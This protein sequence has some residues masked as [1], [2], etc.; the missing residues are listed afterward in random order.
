MKR[1]LAAALLLLAL[2]GCES[3]QDRSARLEAQAAGASKPGKGLVVEQRS[4]AVRVVRAAALQDENGAAVVV[5]LR[6]RSRQALAALPI[7]VAV[8]DKG[9]KPLYANDA[10][11]LDRSL[12]S[13][14]AI[15]PRSRLL[16]VNDQVTAAGEVSRARAAVGVGGKRVA[17]ALPRLVVQGAR[18][19]GDP[20]SGIA[21][22]GRIANR[23][24]LEQRRLVVYVVALKGREIVA[25]GR[26]IVPR[27]RPGKTVPFTAFFIGDPRDARLEVAVPPTV[28]SQ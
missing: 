13:V 11:G 14:P 23:S 9:G 18:L 5:E 6:N 20:V 28:V 24:K 16:W 22:V 7:S 15:G 10:P 21:A 2:A 17:G 3:T 12:V 4:K 25:A 1:R 8:R 26:G 19:E 27:I